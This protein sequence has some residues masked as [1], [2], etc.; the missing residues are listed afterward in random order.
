MCCSIL[1]L[2]STLARVKR[3]S[4]KCLKEQK[5]SRRVSY[6]LTSWMLS[7]LEDQTEPRF[8]VICL[9][10][11]TCIPLEMTSFF[12]FSGQRNC[13]G[14]ESD[15]IRHGRCGGSRTS[16]HFGSY[17]QTRSLEGCCLFLCFHVMYVH[18]FPST[19]SC[20]SFVVFKT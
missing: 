6:F 16:L 4:D 20:L 14:C 19:S 13:Q 2:S 1:Y 7:V 9:C 3:P 5:I 15:V 17:Q 10:N 11:T 8:V 12:F 18:I